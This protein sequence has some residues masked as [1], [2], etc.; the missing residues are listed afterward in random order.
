M[1]LTCGVAILAAAC[2]A[3][4]PEAVAPVGVTGTSAN[5]A[6]AVNVQARA[7]SSLGSE[8][9]GV[10]PPLQSSS[11]STLYVCTA[12]S[13]AH[14]GSNTIGVLGGTVV[15]GNNTLI[16]PPGALLKP[17]LITAT[18]AGDAHVSAQFQPEGL[19][20]LLPAV[21]TLS[22]KQCASPPPPTAT[23]VYL[24]SLLGEILEILPA[25][26]DLGL[27]SI[28]APIWHFSVYAVAD[29]AR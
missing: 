23:I 5:A 20:F 15:F 17:T 28:S 4:S 19:H 24:E 25:K 21:L 10:L 6:A 8:L 18:E 2:D 26:L 27:K 11:S 7:S 22:Y 13:V 1:S 29:R 9:L 12:D 16:V 3:N 14:S